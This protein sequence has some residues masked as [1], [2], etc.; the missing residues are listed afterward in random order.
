MR[1]SASHMQ[2]LVLQP[3]PLPQEYETEPGLALSSPSAVAHGTVGPVT[4]AY[5]AEW[6]QNTGLLALLCALALRRRRRRRRRRRDYG[7]AAMGRIVLAMP[8]S[9][10]PI[11]AASPTRATRQ[12]WMRVTAAPSRSHSDGRAHV[13]STRSGQ[14]HGQHVHTTICIPSS[15]S[16]S[17]LAGRRKI[18][19]KKPPC[20]RAAVERR[21]RRRRRRPA[22][23]GGERGSACKVQPQK[24]RGH[25]DSNNTSRHTVGMPSSRRPTHLLCAYPVHSTASHGHNSSV[26]HPPV[27]CLASSYVYR[28][29]LACAGS[30]RSVCS[31]DSGTMTTRRKCRRAT[32]SSRS[33]AFDPSWSVCSSNGCCTD[34]PGGGFLNEPDH[35]PSAHPPPIALCTGAVPYLECLVIDC[36]RS[37]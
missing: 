29:L 4:L 21:D 11:Q 34:W 32:A 7:Y 23:L 15:M 3:P 37:Q 8:P 24:P 19:P 1:Q 20:S 26:F 36:Q 33:S 27:P 13:G 25:N 16:N 35:P 2:Y 28:N 30:L 12:R 17:I 9:R 14:S 5:G 31:T 6:G 10:F 18:G 22:P